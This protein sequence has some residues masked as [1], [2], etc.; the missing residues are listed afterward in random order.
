MMQLRRH[1]AAAIAALIQTSIGSAALAQQSAGRRRQPEPP[2]SPIVLSVQSNPRTLRWRFTLTNRGPS[3]V[4][5]AVDRNLLALEITPAPPPEPPPGQRRRPARA[6]KVTRCRGALF[7]RITEDVARTQLA[8]NQSYSEGFDLRSLCGVR[9][10]AAFVAGASVVFSYGARGRRPSMSRAIVFDSS[11]VAIEELRADA[12]VLSGDPL[13]A[14][15]AASAAVDEAAA[16]RVSAP[17]SASGDRAGGIIVRTAL[18]TRGPAPRRLFFR[19]SMF[20]LELMTPRGQLHQCNDA[21]RG[22]VG[23]DDYARTVSPRGGP[24]A[25]LSFGLLCGNSPLEE[26]GIYRARVVFESNVQPEGRRA[27]TFQGRAASAWFPV[28]VRR[29]S[30]QL[31]YR[32]LPDADPFVAAQPT[33]DGRAAQA[34]TP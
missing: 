13:A 28:L 5:V 21:P 18:R 9:L 19:P 24:S 20:S 14:E 16:I 32:P 3:A 6:P 27:V 7:P 12:M 30:P 2:P 34:T 26:P 8:P 31:R 1:L 33:T 22:Y 4:E 23:L 25:A 11:A 15:R 10:P 17:S 29:G